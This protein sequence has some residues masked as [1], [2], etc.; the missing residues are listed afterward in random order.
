MTVS[1]MM[2]SI[3]YVTL[4]MQACSTDEIKQN[5]GLCFSL[6]PPRRI[7]WHIR[8]MSALQQ[9]VCV[10][11]EGGL[12]YVQAWAATK[13]TLLLMAH[14]WKMEEPDTWKCCDHYTDSNYPSGGSN[15]GGLSWAH[16][17]TRTHNDKLAIKG[18]GQLNAML[19]GEP[20]T[21]NKAWWQEPDKEI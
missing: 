7:S 10:C 18:G 5:H 14:I 1:T 9:C 8:N 6:P 19:F 12:A 3:I 2:P 20:L 13:T 21:A 11:V 16:T 4:M 17:H 15:G